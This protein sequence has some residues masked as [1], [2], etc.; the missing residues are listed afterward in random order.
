MK[1]KNQVFIAIALILFAAVLKAV[2]YPHSFNPIIAIALFSGVVVTDKKLAFALPLLA[3][4]AS[5]LILEIANIA[6][7]F[8]GWSQIGNYAALLFVT[9][10]GFFMRKINAL[11]VIAFSIA[12][13]LLFFLLS[14]SN[15]FFFDTF[16]TYEHSFNG[17]IDC[18]VAGVPFLNNKMPI[19]L[20]FSGILFGSYVLIFKPY[21][22]KLYA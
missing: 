13:T 6:P 14:N 11:N 22:K 15:T 4:F 21:A 1:Q 16:H 9:V 17:W 12:S 18:L 7:G 10:L 2:T 20:L 19:D 5:D 3:M 8:Y